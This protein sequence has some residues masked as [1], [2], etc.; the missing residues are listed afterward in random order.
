M[1]LDHSLVADFPMFAGLEA[2][3]VDAILGQAKATRFPKGVA[4]FK[5]GSEAQSFLL[6]LYGR[7]RVIRST[8]TGEQVVMRYVGPGDL[9]G[10][11]KAIGHSLYPASAIAVV[12]SVALQ[13]PS[14]RW[15]AL[16]QRHPGLLAA[17]LHTMGAR[18]QE[19]DARVVEMSTEDVERRIAHALLRLAQQAGRKVEQGLEISFPLSRRDIAEMTGTTL[20][21]VSR[22]LCGWESHGWIE[23]GRQRVV[24]RNVRQLLALS[25]SAPS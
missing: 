13:W 12:D 8:P 25:Q 24:L 6:L 23:G 4:V 11:A 1:L 19:A 15:P 21:T 22:I 2:G 14:A 3:E 5:Q 20:Y 9:C 7:L 18:L 17:A 16:T 10:L